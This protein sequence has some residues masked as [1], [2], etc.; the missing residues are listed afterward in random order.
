M[1]QDDVNEIQDK[2]IA[3]KMINRYRGTIKTKYNRD[4]LK[5]SFL[6]LDI[7]MSQ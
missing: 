1:I 4:I 5:N 7:K 3:E 2:M 6:I